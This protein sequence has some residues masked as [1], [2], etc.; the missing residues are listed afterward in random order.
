LDEYRRGRD[1][2]LMYV[3]SRPQPDVGRRS[4]C[5]R[6]PRIVSAMWQVVFVGL[7]GSL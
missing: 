4:F 5:E 1:R 6:K 3:P 7:S 2:T